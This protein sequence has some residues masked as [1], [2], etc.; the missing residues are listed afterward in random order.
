M[1][2]LLCLHMVKI[3][4][5][6]NYAIISLTIKTRKIVEIALSIEND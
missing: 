2:H 6:E 5:L 3:I 1:H 4:V